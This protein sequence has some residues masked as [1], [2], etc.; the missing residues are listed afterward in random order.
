[1]SDIQFSR[2]DASHVT[3]LTGYSFDLGEAHKKTPDYYVSKM[4]LSFED[5]HLPRGNLGAWR[6]GFVTAVSAVNITPKLTCNASRR[7]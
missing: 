5:V 4:E 7:S 1:M 3:N 6:C 2:V